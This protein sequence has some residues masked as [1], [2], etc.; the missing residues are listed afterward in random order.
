MW[1]QNNKNWKKAQERVKVCFKKFESSR[2]NFWF[3]E[4]PDTYQARGEIIQE[5]PS[6]MWFLYNGD[7]G[8]IE[9]K[10]CEQNRF[11]F[12]DIRPSQISGAM[13]VIAAGGHTIFL[14]CKLPE[15]QW[16]YV[17]GQKILDSRRNGN[18]S[19]TWSEMTPIKLIAEDILP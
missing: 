1:K 5:Q 6:D 11:P 2:K 12:K 4:F 19:M 16:H 10:T 15:W 18:K 17:D 8:L 13:R 9:I 14:I 3:K 7:F